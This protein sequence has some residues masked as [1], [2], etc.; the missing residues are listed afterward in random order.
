LPASAS[1]TSSVQFASAV[2]SAVQAPPLPVEVTVQ[3]LAANANGAAADNSN[4]TQQEARRFMT[5]P[6]SGAGIAG[7]PE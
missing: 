3:V 5:S 4:P 6:R 2:E 7:Y 1:A